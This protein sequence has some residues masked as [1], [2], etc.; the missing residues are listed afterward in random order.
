MLQKPT[1][2]ADLLP[3]FDLIGNAGWDL[4]LRQVLVDYEVPLPTPCCEAELADCEERIGF[5]LPQSLR[6]FLLAIG[7]IDFDGLRIFSPQ[8]IK[9]AESFWFAEYFSE[10]AR[11]QLPQLLQFAEAVADNVYVME[12]QSGKC[13]LCCHDPAGLIDWL[14]SFDTLIKIAV[15][16]LSW[17]YY[18]WPDDEIEEMAEELKAELYP[19]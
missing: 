11:K 17:S 1:T 10:I 7:P 19:S 14:P 16:D 5:A 4:A 3:P 6:L 9:T 8:K 2:K 13:C 15:I 18:G 12:L